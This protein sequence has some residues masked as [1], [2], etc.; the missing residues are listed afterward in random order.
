MKVGDDSQLARGVIVNNGMVDDPRFLEIV[1]EL[2]SLQDMFE[3]TQ[4][5]LFGYTSIPKGDNLIWLVTEGNRLY[6]EIRALEYK[7]KQLAKVVA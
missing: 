1:S 7:L 6:H 5:D 3:R 4:H 2:S